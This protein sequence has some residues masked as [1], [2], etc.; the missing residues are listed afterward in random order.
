MV[1]KNTKS[2]SNSQEEVDKN[3]FKKL[4]NKG[5]KFNPKLAASY[6]NKSL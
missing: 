5:L 3:I 6:T 4:V 1:N 2:H